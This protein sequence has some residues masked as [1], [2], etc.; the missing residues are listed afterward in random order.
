MNLQLRS[1]NTPSFR[2]RFFLTIGL[3]TLVRIGSFIP[4]PYIDIKTFSPLLES[5]ASTTA[6]ATILNS[7]SGGENA[8]FSI[9]SLGI[10]PNINASIIIQLLTT[11]NPTLLKLQ[12]EEGE[13]GRR[14][15]TD[16]T[17]YLTFFCAI[18]ESVVTT[19]SFRP[20]IFNWNIFVLIQ[21][22]L[23]LIAGSMIILWFSELITKDGIGNGSSILIC[24]NIVSNFPD[25]LRAMILAL[26]NQNI[27]VSFF[28]GGIFLLTTVGCIYINEAMVKIP[29]VSA[30][31]LLRNV[32]KFSLWNNSNLPLRV[33]QAGVMPL[34]F[35]SSVMVILSSLTSLVYGQLI[36]IELFS[37]LNSLPT[38]LTLGVGKIFYW[39]TYGI[40]VFFFTSF[41]ST[42]LLDPKDMTEQFR[43]NSVTIKG[44]TP[45][46][47]TQSYLSIT[48]KRLTILNAVFLIG[49][50]ILLNGLEYLLPVNNL[51][52]RGFGLTSQLILVNVLVD[53]FRKVRN[54]L[55]AETM[56]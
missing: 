12:K 6:V 25:Q 53:T 13:Y 39:F 8:S 9:L 44:I 46:K 23:T 30:S 51:N 50:L 28:I 29:L 18:I 56:F 31:Q 21:I 34:V 45:G 14:K 22:S 32:N 7:F 26:S 3:L 42:I 16:Y 27:I 2:Q 36:N 33:N 5:N 10:L 11:I 15:L 20:L 52:L 19:Y 41:Y 17:R 43:K 49:V 1:K 4:L 38:T 54:L 24:F 47:S 55:N 40:L 37:F 35:T 48:I